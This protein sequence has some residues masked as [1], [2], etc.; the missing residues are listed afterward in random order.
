MDINRNPIGKNLQIDEEKEFDWWDQIVPRYGTI[1]KNLNLVN[2]SWII[3]THCE[4]MQDN[5]LLQNV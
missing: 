5:L 3:F 1:S 2:S 4:D